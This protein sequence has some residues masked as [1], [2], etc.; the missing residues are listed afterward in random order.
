MPDRKPF[1][2]LPTMLP[3]EEASA[4]T[5]A[6]AKG[7]GDLFVVGIGA[8]AGGLEACKR[9]LAALPADSGLAFIIVQHLDPNHESMMVT[10]LSGSTEM[11]VSQ[12][13]EGMLVE[14]DNVYVIPP[15]HYLSISD[16]VLHLT[17]PVER[18]GARLPFD[19][20]LNAMAA[21][22]GAHAACVILS[23]SGS[24]GTLGIKAIKR[25]GGIVIAQDPK[26]A[27]YDGMPRNA[28]ESG[29]VDFILPISGIAERL[30]QFKKDFN[31]PKDLSRLA[32]I[33]TLL[34]SKTSH[35]FTLYKA[36]T[37]ERRIARRMAV[38]GF[39]ENDSDGYLAVLATD[40]TERDQL[41]E[42]LLINVTQFFRDAKVFETLSADLIPEIVSNA[43]DQTI[44]IWVAG[45]STGEETYSLAMLF[46]E[47]IK[48]VNSAIKLQ[49]FASDVDPEAVA[50]ARE[51]VYPFSIEGAVSTQ[52]LKQFFNKEER[53]YA[54]SVELR[55]SVIFAVHDVL[56]DPPFSNLDLISCRN[57]L[58]YLQPEAQ[59]KVI[60]IF[61]FA[62]RKN[63][64][65]L[66]GS[67]E[68]VSASDD[69]FSVISKS[70][71]L[72]RKTGSKARHDLQFEIPGG[73]LV[74][75]VSRTEPASS[76]ETA[77]DVGELCR[78]IVLEIH[79]PASV[80]INER[81]ETLYSSGPTEL[82]LQVTRGYPTQDLGAMM[83]PALR[84]RVKVALS[85]ASR[86]KMRVIMPGGV[87]VRDGIAIPFNI[88][89]V[90]ASSPGSKLFLV[91][92]VDQPTPTRRSEIGTAIEAD[93]SQMGELRQ[94][95]SD[96]R[97]EL[98]TMFQN[99]D[100]SKQEQNLRNEEALSINEEFQSTNE[101]LV[102][103]KEEL[104]SLNEELTALNSQLQETLERSRTTSND[105]QN[106]LYSTDVATLFLDTDLKIR[107]FT[108]ATKSIF[109]IIATDIGRPL[110]DFHWVV[111]DDELVEDAL[112]VLEDRKPIER[113]IEAKDGGWF[114]RRILPYRTH[115]NADGG[116]VITFTNVTQRKKTKL[117]LKLAQ[118]DA[119][120]ANAAK[121]RFMAA[122]SHDLRQ[123][124]QTLTLLTALLSKTTISEAGK[125]F[126]IKMEETTDSM[127][128]ILNTLLD[129]NQIDAG[130][131]KPELESVPI[132][133]LIERL[134]KEFIYLSE[135]RGLALRTVPCSL[136]VNSD[137]RIIE[138]MIRNLISNAIK[139]TKKGTILIG[140]RRHRDRLSIQV[141][142]SGL[143]IPKAELTA[144]FNEFHQIDNIRHDRSQ[145]LG[146]GLS[147]VQR[148]AHLLGH[149]VQV[150]SN[151]G[152]GSVFSI[153][154]EVATSPPK[155][156]EDISEKDT[157]RAAQ[158]S[159]PKIG[160]ILI[161]EDDPDI[162]HLLEM[163]L[164]EEGHA[165]A[166]ANC[167]ESALRIA[168]AAIMKPDIVIVD[169][170]LSNSTNGLQVVAQLRK[171]LAD[172]FS[173]I[174]CTGDIS[175]KTLKS[176]AESDCM[177]MSKPMKL[178][179][180][181]ENIQRALSEKE[182]ITNW[183]L[184]AQINVVPQERR[185]IFVVD[186]DAAFRSAMT[187][188]FHSKGYHVEGFPDCETFLESAREEINTCLILDSNLPGINGLE[189][190]QKLS[191]SQSKIPVIMLTGQGDIK[192]AVQAMKE[193]AIDFVEK[194]ASKAK[195][196]ACVERAFEH[197]R[198]SEK[199]T[200]GRE[201]AVG[202]IASLTS[203]Q[204][205]IMDLVLAGHPSKNIAADLFISQRT[206][207]NH[208]ASIMEK[209]GT[210]SLPA[211]A[212][213]AV[214]A[215]GTS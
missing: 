103:S 197:A 156:F 170:N 13:V 115:D 7:D 96:A 85:T 215:A 80:L 154:V 17:L 162:R 136:Y 201:R 57:L 153:E 62:L 160:S 93:T 145:G 22:V 49:I 66:L 97:A 178:N 195:L 53:G 146:L 159:A 89:I 64:V 139:Y 110:T 125:K 120:Q 88:D 44:R 205:Q 9:L 84:A 105:L 109:M 182:V 106:V 58:I 144:I 91:S 23:G 119:E 175:T 51:G 43:V 137:P 176:I 28:I 191:A 46:S 185:T 210:K 163:F 165:V 199:L 32:R 114:S 180:L 92:F 20:L 171:L 14:I 196:L 37:L 143:G 121:S 127:G 61:N 126:L 194:P 113:D 99:Q 54:V 21:S 169:Y 129:I 77:I 16:N 34:R 212:R 164:I 188:I 47:H 209:T 141:W 167:G 179:D 155:I 70:A 168:S 8:S 25:G 124:L 192:V 35:D 4:Q 130:I 30:I 18:H 40:P 36:G 50:A 204:R 5:F 198:G 104:Q 149:D 190:L 177:H 140:C 116:V 63:G 174:V 86:D 213:L 69:R 214:L 83:Q 90:P 132:G 202:Q 71:R 118:E 42:D 166:A 6:S 117:A 123:P 3:A 135:S 128:G 181:K 207:E 98:E 19:F 112:R 79:A 173:V 157:S 111:G 60:S 187:A 87:T 193:G 200:A 133:D 76:P 203:R 101:E 10:L 82:Y 151:L 211:L 131:I 56:A 148:L 72:F 27:G 1:R 138:Q 39:S 38:A 152:K 2:D 12:A 161:V 147:I 189:M 11:S 183:K 81:M 31:L 65:L 184:P 122:A 75:A 67:A 73:R 158:N 108:P 68:T 52:R 29:K 55:A 150:R 48:S 24:D 33:I 134:G 100:L 15:G 78:R 94:E 206:V 208:R 142:D 95:L 172:S 102:T 26:E 74:R 41:V 186:D 107:F 59:A 45:C